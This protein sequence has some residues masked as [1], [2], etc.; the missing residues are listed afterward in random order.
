[1]AVDLNAPGEKKVTVGSEI[2][3]GHDAIFEV[4]GPDDLL[5]VLDKLDRVFSINK[6][7]NTDTPGFLLGAFF[8][9]WQFL[10]MRL[11]SKIPQANRELAY[12]YASGYY[13][14]FRKLQRKL[15]I[16]DD[17][18]QEAVGM[19]KSFAEEAA[20]WEARTKGK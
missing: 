19:I 6:Q 20:R 18:L 4:T 2:K 9:S 10:N 13:R 11:E 17:K 14:D 1:M 16:N 12:K 15:K 5:R 8:A 7:K 3:R